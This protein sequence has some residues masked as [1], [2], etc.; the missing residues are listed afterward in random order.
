[1]FERFTREARAVVTGAVGEAERRRDRHVGT[2]HL[3]LG[4]IASDDP[5]IHAV[6]DA[7]GVDLERAR[8]VLEA[9][10][11][12]ALAAVGVDVRTMPA[13]EPDLPER[14]TFG[15]RNPS[16]HRPFT[17]GAKHALE[18]T[19]REALQRNDRRIGT[20]HIL[21][22]LTASSARDPAHQLLTALGVDVAALRADLE[23]RLANA[24]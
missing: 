16:G 2:E 17:G 23:R 20:E 14:R 22:A 5:V 3:L 11:R 24:A 8:Q 9:G 1:M 19:L 15:F 13:P 6:I 21:L 7:A 4:I 18:S 12:E 10:D